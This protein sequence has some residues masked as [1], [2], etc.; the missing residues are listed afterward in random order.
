VNCHLLFFTPAVVASLLAVCS[1]V[2]AQPVHSSL[3]FAGPDGRLIYKPHTPNGDIIRPW[4]MGGL[5]D[6]I[7]G[8]IAL[9]DRQWMGSGHGW[10]GANYVAWNCVGPRGCQRPPTAQNIA[11]GHV[12]R[13]WEGAFQ[14]PDGFWELAGSHVQPR[15]LY[16]QQLADRLGAE[17]VKQISRQP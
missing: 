12:G 10:A 9:Q 1:L 11:I 7:R 16:L 2:A 17:A 8:N 15:S 4:S 3:A 5:F 14:R 13:H 6:N